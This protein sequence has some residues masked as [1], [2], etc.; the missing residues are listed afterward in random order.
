VLPPI[1][2][3][4]AAQDVYNAAAKQ[5]NPEL[6]VMWAGQSVGLINDL[7]GAADVVHTIVREARQVLRGF[8]SRVQP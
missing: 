7:P 6:Y 1:V 4:S 3:R 8:D 2:Q 5:Q